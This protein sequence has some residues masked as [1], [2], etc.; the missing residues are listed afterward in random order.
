MNAK[1]DWGFAG[2][3]VEAMWLMLQQDQPDD[4]I[5]STGETHAVR[6][7]CELAF[8]EAGITIVWKGEGI[9]EKGIDSGTGKVLI[10]V[11]PRYFRPTE[12]ELLV[13]DPSKAK[14]KLGW[15]PKVNFQELIKMMVSADLKEAEHEVFCLKEGYPYNGIRQQNLYSRS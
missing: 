13:G 3:Y 11:D 14:D 2:D 7:F 8:Q 6:E 1:R 4:Y 12:V 15:I 9:H 10:E 5:I